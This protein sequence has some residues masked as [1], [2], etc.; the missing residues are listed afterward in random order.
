MYCPQIYV[1]GLK[2]TMK[3]LMIASVLSK[4]QVRPPKTHVQNW[5]LQQASRLLMIS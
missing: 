2:E 5:L 1:E 4:I 3:T